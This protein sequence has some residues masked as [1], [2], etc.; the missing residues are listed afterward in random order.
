MNKQQHTR[1]IW[2][3]L[4]MAF[5]LSNQFPNLIMFGII[6]KNYLFAVL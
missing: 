4:S 5:Y 3:V 1:G 6:F 2:K